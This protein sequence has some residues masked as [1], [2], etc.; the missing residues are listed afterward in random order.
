MP[1]PDNSYYPLFPI[2][3]VIF[4]QTTGLALAAGI[5]SFYRDIAPSV[6]KNVYQRTENPDNTF[7]YTSLGNVLTLSA[8][9]SFVDG[10]GNNIIP[11]LWPFVGLP[12]DSPPS[13]VIDLYYITVE[14]SG[15]TSEFTV[16]AW[17]PEVS[18]S[19]SGGNETF[20][21]TNII[22]NP[23]FAVINY[24]SPTTLTIPDPV[25]A[26][27]NIQIAPD[28]EIITTGSGT[29]TISQIAVTDTGAPGLP[30]FAL[31]IASSGVTLVLSQT[32]KMSPRILETGFA[33][34]T[35]IAMSNDASTHPIEMNYVPSDPAMTSQTIC[36]VA[37]APG[38][39]TAGYGNENLSSLSI[40]PD[41]GSVG[42]VNVQLVIPAN[43]SVQISCVQLISVAGTT[44]LP[45]YIQES[46]P[47]QIDHIYHDAYPIVPVGTIIDFAG[48]AVPAHYL[49]CDGSIKS[50]VIY[51]LLFHTLTLNLTATTVD[52]T[53]FTV[54]S[55]A[56]LGL[57][58]TVEGTGIPYG[59]TIIGIS[60]LTVQLSQVTTIS[61][62]FT[63][64][65]LPWGQGSNDGS[66][67][68]SLPDLRSQVLAG[69][70]G[71]LVAISPL[72]DAVGQEAGAA[73][74]T[75]AAN[76]IAP[77]THGAASS[78]TGNNS[79]GSGDGSTIYTTNSSGTTRSAIT[80]TV[81]NNVPSPSLQPVS[82]VQQTTIVYKYIRFE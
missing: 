37:A 50:R 40:N 30:A 15:M 49:L 76:Q 73:S 53:H 8:I 54:A 18:S 31:S 9:G 47:R 44:D 78:Y 58:M 79:A 60:T 7:T 59:T 64:T 80:I 35:F 22:S 38:G 65:F 28:W 71:N 13:T 26:A 6:P 4:D 66:L 67:T 1:L 69:T 77:H 17:P 25:T 2:Q 5:V 20:P 16:S 27:Q 42:Y 41:S 52:S 29:V 81:A 3:E 14:S 75:L 23:Q 70:G 46:T 68:F 32:I 36:T 43:S 34:G 62:T 56:G 72:L 82:I 39:F 48:F 63:A 12:T 57:G 51:N 55:V 45:R 10:S 33:A 11:F 21:S 61:G 74:V 19:G 24:P